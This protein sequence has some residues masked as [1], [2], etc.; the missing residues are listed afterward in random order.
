MLLKTKFLAPAYNPKSVDRD[1][2]LTRLNN[3]H[4][5]KL[6][7]VVA[8]AGYGKTTLVT[9]WI[10]SQECTYCWLALDESDNDT[11][12]F[13]QYVVGTFSN[14]LK[15]LGHEPQHLLAQKE[16]PIEAV[17]TALVNEIS[18]ISNEAPV[19]LILDD[20]HL[21]DNTEIH[22]TISFLIDYLPPSVQ[23]IITS[24]V[25]PSL[26]VARWRVKNIIDEIHAH[27]LA[28]SIEESRLFF[29]EYMN[30]NLSDEDIALAREKTEGWVAA[31]QL[32]VISTQGNPSSVSN[33]EFFKSYSGEDRLISDYVLSE[34]LD[35]Q[36][37]DVKEFLLTTSCLIRL[38]AGLCN[39]LRDNNNSQLYLDKLNQINLFII[40]LDTQNNW[41]RYHDLFRESLLQRLKHSNPEKLK[42]LQKRAINWLLDQGHM[43]EA[44]YQLIQLEDWQWLSKVLE[45]RGNTLIH[46]GHHLPVLEWLSHL[47]EETLDEHPRLLM[48][49][50]WALFFGNKID[51]ISP[52]LSRLEDILDKRV[53]DS[54]PEAQDALALHSEISLIRSH[55]ARSQSDI[56]TASHLTQQV[57]DDLNNSDMPLKSVT[58]YGLGMDCFAKGDLKSARSALEASIQHGKKEKKYSTVLSSTG[59]LGWILY[60]QGEL[61][62]ARETCTENQLWIDSYHDQSQPKL[63]SCWQNCA[64]AQIYKEKNQITVAESYINPL[65]KH[66]EA[67]TEPGQHIL[68]QYT[69]AHL[70]FSVGN[71]NDAISWLDDALNVFDHKKTSLTFEPPSI[72]ALR[73]RCYLALNEPEKAGHWAKIARRTNSSTASPVNKEQI[74]TTIARSLIANGHYQDAINSIASVFDEAKQGGH[75]KHLIELWTVKALAHAKLNDVENARSSINEALVLATKDRFIRIFCEEAPEV[76]DL[77]LLADNNAIPNSYKTEL[78]L[79]LDI[80]EKTQQSPQTAQISDLVSDNSL[81]EPLSQREQ[82]VLTLINAG[83]ANKVIANQLFLAPATI[84]AHIRNI[85]G[86]IGAKSRTE[87]L[88]KA[89]EFGLL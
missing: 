59:L 16:L 88:A 44:I 80:N 9:Q 60:H 45:E 37:D 32:A 26:P 13:W 86:K 28:F 52:L 51:I 20:Y 71:F 85:Y 56:S 8:P 72:E 7:T 70:A 36:S 47:S 43:H 74:A 3:R 77:I 14:T 84:K 54:H 50:V 11:R 21:I 31:M 64:L 73:A 83:L 12:R 29:N 57:L 62:L 58:Y 81:Q 75:V 24:R 76:R 4:G 10:H 15:S 53:C 34:I 5:R 2:L 65:L 55:L 49:K 66:L 25:E 17:V 38:N 35:A 67:G 48:L 87:A 61:D 18:S 82:E 78:H 19:Y 39:A 79:A 33:L 89:R 1:R 23:L 22:Q 68:I 46:E 42:V 63:I 27:D 41:F 30:L 69:R 40:P 6:I